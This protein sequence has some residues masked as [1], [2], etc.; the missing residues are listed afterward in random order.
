MCQID[1]LNFKG[2][3]I[4]FYHF[5]MY[6]PIFW[7]FS[8][9]MISHN[10]LIIFIVLS[11]LIYFILFFFFQ[12]QVGSLSTS[13]SSG[14]FG[15]GWGLEGGGSSQEFDITTQIPESSSRSRSGSG[16]NTPRRAQTQPSRT[17]AVPARDTVVQKRKPFG[18]P[19][20]PKVRSPKNTPQPPTSTSTSTS[21]SVV[22]ETRTE[23]DIT[24]NNDVNKG[25]E[26]GVF[27]ASNSS[28]VLFK[29]NAQGTAGGN[30]EQLKKYQKKDMTEGVGNN[31]DNGDDDDSNSNEE[32]QRRN[33]EKKNADSGEDSPSTGEH[34]LAENSSETKWNDEDFAL[35]VSV[36]TNDI[37]LKGYTVQRNGNSTDDNGK[38][39]GKDN[40][41]KFDG[42][43]AGEGGGGVEEDKK[44]D[45]GGEQEGEGMKEGE[46]G[47]GGGAGGGGE[48][49]GLKSLRDDSQTVHKYVTPLSLLL[50]CSVTA[51]QLDHLMLFAQ[52]VWAPSLLLS[53]AFSSV[54]ISPTNDNDKNIMKFPGATHFLQFSLHFTSLHFTS[55]CL[56]F[57]SPLLSSPFL[58]SYLIFF[59]F[60]IFT[61]YFDAYHLPFLTAFILFTFSL[62]TEFKILYLLFPV[63]CCIPPL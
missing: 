52:P 21:T 31:N 38:V 47:V 1:F 36:R 7:I 55:Y 10:L 54:C 13:G 2:D 5:I 46:E 48:V 17:E 28:D 25:R 35:S 42:E 37:P 56:E 50:H 20:S 19:A 26:R 29:R 32:I 22:P 57:S 61:I 27:H 63:I 40:G 49:G 16:G 59:S 43:G 53:M 30:A 14:M 44:S 23:N 45:K 34:S 24:K 39:N 58:S 33:V 3:T 41:K 11:I 9:V 8:F 6:F 12:L 62:L 51:L 4:S 60:S 15:G 18:S